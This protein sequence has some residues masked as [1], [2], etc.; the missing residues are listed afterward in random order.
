M[1]ALPRW[2]DCIRIAVLL[3]VGAADFAMRNSGK[4]YLEI[5][6]AGGEYGIR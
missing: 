6:Q 5:A 3:E 1:V 4:S 2:I